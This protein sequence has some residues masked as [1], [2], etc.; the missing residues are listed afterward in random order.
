MDGD[1]GA[2]DPDGDR[3]SPGD[4]ATLPRRRR[5]GER[6]TPA[7]FGGWPGNNLSMMRPQRA[8][9]RNRHR[10]QV[11]VQ[12]KADRAHNDRACAPTAPP[13]ST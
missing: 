3:K 11:I 1:G 9:N 2:C 8:A 10:R 7:N 4:R 5:R 6:A 12:H 13:T